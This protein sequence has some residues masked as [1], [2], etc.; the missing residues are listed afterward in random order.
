[1]DSFTIEFVSDA[2]F[3]FHPK[4]SLNSFTNFQ[5]KQIHLKGEWEVA[6]PEISYSS[7]YQNFTRRGNVLVLLQKLLGELLFPLLKNI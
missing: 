5:P 3:N 2:S 7:M 6:I 4:N 1:M